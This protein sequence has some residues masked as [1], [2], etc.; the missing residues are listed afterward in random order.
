MIRIRVNCCFILIIQDMKLGMREEGGCPFVHFDD[1]NLLALLSDEIRDDSDIMNKIF[2]Q[3]MLKNPIQACYTYQAA[4]A[5][6]YR[7]P[8]SLSKFQSPVEY[9]KSMKLC[10]NTTLE[11]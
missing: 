11:W 5:R 10:F 6:K 2:E 7:L 4:C 8:V 1:T 9:Y 3:R